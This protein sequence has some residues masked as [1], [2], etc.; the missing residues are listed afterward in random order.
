MTAVSQLV[1]GLIVFATLAITLGAPAETASTPPRCA[2]L[3]TPPTLFDTVWLAPPCMT[4]TGPT[5]LQKPPD[6]SP[7]RVRTIVRSTRISWYGLVAD[8][9]TD[10]WDWPCA[11][12]LCGNL[13]ANMEVYSPWR[14][15]VASPLWPGSSVPV[16]PLGTAV[17][18][19]T[20]PWACVE[21]VVTDTCPGCSGRWPT[22]WV[23]LSPALYRVLAPLQTGVTTG[24]IWITE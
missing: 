22:L 4:D 12:D 8:W 1:L 24:V 7:A 11:V 2:G 9:R 15:S 13:M 18:I 10:V 23:D 14:A 3:G 19:C 17:R 6:Q 16:I 5:Y 21:G 20:L